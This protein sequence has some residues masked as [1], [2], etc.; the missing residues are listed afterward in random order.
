MKRW[1]HASSG[2]ANTYWE[3]LQEQLE[4]DSEY[5]DPLY[6]QTDAGLELLRIIYEVHSSLGVWAKPSVIAGEGGIW[7]YSTK[8]DRYS[9]ASGIDYKEFN[10]SVLSIAF[11]SANS[12][13]FKSKYRSYLKYILDEYSDEKARN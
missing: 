4:K 13:D 7:F 10:N 5:T 1:I 12:E 3:R 6:E 11:Q 2:N 9:I 8:D